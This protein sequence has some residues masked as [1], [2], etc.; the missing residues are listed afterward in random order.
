MYSNDKNLRK[1]SATY[2]FTVKQANWQ[3]QNT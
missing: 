1:A 2:K 3:N